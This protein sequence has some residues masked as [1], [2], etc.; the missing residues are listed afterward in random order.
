MQPSSSNL[1]NLLS[2]LLYRPPT[3]AN[4]I[5]I[6]NTKPDITNIKIFRSIAYYKDKA[7]GLKKLDPT[8]KKAILVS[9]KIFTDYII[10][11]PKGL[12]RLKILRY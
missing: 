1:L 7:T 12:F 8:A 2:C 5:N 6:Y 11:I 4:Q 3:S 10:S 9:L